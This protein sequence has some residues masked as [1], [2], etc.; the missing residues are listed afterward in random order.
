MQNESNVYTGC[1]LLPKARVWLWTDCRQKVLL[2]R[3]KKSLTAP[4]AQTSLRSQ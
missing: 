4:S 2:V 3:E 1:D